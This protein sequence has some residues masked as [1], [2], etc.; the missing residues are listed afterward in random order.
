MSP[1]WQY[2]RVNLVSDEIERFF[3]AKLLQSGEDL[4]DGHFE[5][6]EVDRSAFALLEVA[7]GMQSAY[8]MLR[9]TV[10]TRVT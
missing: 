9:M 2:R 8:A 3:A 10:L 7:S 5:S 1:R 6:R 4:L